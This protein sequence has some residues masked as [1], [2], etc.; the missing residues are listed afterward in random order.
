MF[1]FCFCCH[2]YLLWEAPVTMVLHIAGYQ[3]SSLKVSKSLYMVLGW[4]FIKQVNWNRAWFVIYSWTD[5][6]VGS[7]FYNES[8]HEN[9]NKLEQLFSQSSEKCINIFIKYID[10]GVWN[11]TVSSYAHIYLPNKTLQIQV[12]N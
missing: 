2:S 3:S 11:C 6:P 12:I 1:F 9:M 10:G 7:K 8:A 4:A 5:L